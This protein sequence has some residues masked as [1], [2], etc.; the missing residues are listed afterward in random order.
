MT[1]TEK[2]INDT[3][4][5]FNEHQRQM[6]K[7]LSKV[8]ERGKDYP[9]QPNRKL[10]DYIETLHDMY[11]EKFH[12]TRADLESRVF[13]DEPTSLIAHARSVRPRSQSP[14]HAK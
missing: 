13:F 14:Y 12:K 8:Q 10:E 2:L 9:V 5:P 3:V 1:N 6:L 4:S 11:P 7:D